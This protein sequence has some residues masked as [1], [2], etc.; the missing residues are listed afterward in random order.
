MNLALWVER[1]VACAGLRDF[2]AAWKHHQELVARHAPNDNPMTLGTLA[3]AAA[4][5]ALLER[6]TPAFER[7]AAEMER[8]FRATG[9]PALVAQAEELRNASSG[10]FQRWEEARR[11]STVTAPGAVS[12]AQSILAECRGPEARRRKALELVADRAGVR[13][14]WLFTVGAAG[15]PELAEA[16]GGTPHPDV[17]PAVASVFRQY[18]SD[19]EETSY[20][21]QPDSS[22]F[23][24][25]QEEQPFRV[26]P[27]TVQ[28]SPDA[29]LVGA[30]AVPSG[31]E[32]RLV[33]YALLAELAAQLFQAGDVGSARLH[34]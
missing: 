19:A 30:I 11:E 24:I 5:I 12:F 10:A 1:A 2:E 14:A 21:D 27:L 23:Q 20:V 26:F 9:N 8:W 25:A 22:S 4:R 29:L 31:P 16:L 32:A 7:A 28:R 15:E 33:S 3:G 13:E 34:G 6:D 18:L 17:P